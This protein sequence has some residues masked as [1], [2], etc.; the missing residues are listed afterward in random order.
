MQ[1][2]VS[3]KISQLNF[4]T[5]IWQVSKSSAHLRM[6]NVS[7]FS[8]NTFNKSKKS[9]EHM[10]ISFVNGNKDEGGRMSTIWESKFSEVIIEK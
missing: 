9:R 4:P 1:T 6:N 10:H 3:W 8:S 2:Y 5:E 7:Q